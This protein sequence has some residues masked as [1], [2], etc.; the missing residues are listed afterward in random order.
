MCYSLTDIIQILRQGDSIGKKSGP[1]L[2][3]YAPNHTIH[4]SCRTRIYVPFEVDIRK[5]HVVYPGKQ[6]NIPNKKNGQAPGPL[7]KKSAYQTSDIYL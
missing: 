4:V 2:F 6:N 7:Q 5:T 3:A 1:I